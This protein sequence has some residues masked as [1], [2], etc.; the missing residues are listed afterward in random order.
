MNRYL[1]VISLIL[2]CVLIPIIN[3][4]TNN[5]NGYNIIWS[6]FIGADNSRLEGVSISSSSDG[7]Y[8]IYGI[9]HGYTEYAD[10]FKYNYPIIIKV[11][12]NGFPQWSNVFSH[13]F[14]GGNDIIETPDGGYNL[15]RWGYFTTVNTTFTK[16]DKNGQVL[17]TKKYPFSAHSFF[18]KAD[19]Y[20]FIERS[21]DAIEPLH[22]INTIHLIKTDFDGNIINTN[23]FKILGKNFGYSIKGAY[24]KDNTYVFAITWDADGYTLLKTDNK[25]NILWEYSYGP[26]SEKIKNYIENFNGDNNNYGTDANLK[27]IRELSDGDICIYY[28]KDNVPHVVRLSPDGKLI[29][30]SKNNPGRISGSN[31][32][33]FENSDDSSL[34]LVDQKNILV[35]DKV[36][37]LSQAWS[38][39]PSLEEKIYGDYGM[40]RNIDGSIIFMYNYK[41]YEVLSQEKVGMVLKVKY[42]THNDDIL[43]LQLKK[44][45]NNRFSPNPLDR[46]MLNYSPGIMAPG[47]EVLSVILSIFLLI[48]LRVQF[49]K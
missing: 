23:S 42:K 19:G 20:L 7:G 9:V 36:G 17:I 48:L 8:L 24:L 31:A 4:Q 49:I 47:F 25:G 5:E 43:L 16:F 46:K 18:Q 15:I 26:D 22:N 2:I 39:D 45:V 28:S 13:D 1:L 33:V 40:I 34:L 38:L 35:A 32:K 27:S 3:A 14:G 44:G 37:Y 41:D 21:W 30:E 10:V 11:D 6:D 12:E 29:W